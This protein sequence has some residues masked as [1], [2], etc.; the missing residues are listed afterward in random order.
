M[1]GLFFTLLLLAHGGFL[2]AGS[3]YPDPN[4][5][6]PALNV[7]GVSSRP[8]SAADPVHCRCVC[9]GGGNKVLPR[10]QAPEQNCSK[11]NGTRCTQQKGTASQC[12]EWWPQ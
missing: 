4:G 2:F 10:T 12:A 6:A 1:G 8:A 7:R 9:S 11:V 5:V 3:A